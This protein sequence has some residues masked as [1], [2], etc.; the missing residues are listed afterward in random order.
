METLACGHVAFAAPSRM[1]PHLVRPVREGVEHV[2]LLTGR[3]LEFDLACGQCDAAGKPVTLVE[4]CEGCAQRLDEDAEHGSLTAW[5]GQP[6]VDERPEAVDRSVVDWRLPE[7]TGPVI[8]LAP[9]GADPG[10]LALTADGTIAEL[11]PDADRCAVLATG[12]LVAEPD[13]QPWAGRP[14]TPRLHV[15]DCGRF[16]AVVNDY[17]RYG[18][19]VDLHRPGTTTL[20]L[21]SGSYRTNLV[22]FSL[23]FARHEGRAVVVHRTDWNRLDVHDAESGRLLTDRAREPV[24]AG[25]RQAHD[26][27]YFH[28]RLHLSPDQRWLADDGWVWAPVGMPVSWSLE[29]W[30]RDNVWESEDGPSWRPLCQRDYRWDTPMCFVGDTLV[31]VSGIGYDDIAMLDG[32]RIFSVVTGAEVSTFAG[33]VGALFADR[34]RLYAAAPGGLQVWDPVT[35]HRTGSVPGFVPTCHHRAAGQL[36][37]VQD[38]VLRRWDTAGG[39]GK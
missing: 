32:V 37:A 8:D 7:L 2:R 26:L 23:V 5:R 12:V 22:P 24:G 10:W 6:G 1:C 4:V 25:Q 29:R 39:H 15:S 27:D 18:R 9:F 11:D 28:G 35:G 34:S 17:G 13:Y 3:R 19:V 16:A 14:L 38:G 20:R 21:D 31:A 33:P 30:L 36:A